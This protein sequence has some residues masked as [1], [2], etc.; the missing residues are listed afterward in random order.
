MHSRSRRLF[1]A[2]AALLLSAA[3]SAD[4]L[5]MLVQRSPL[6]GA[7]YHRLAEAWP[8]M[9]E[10]DALA[11]EREPDNRHDKRAIRVLWRGI[12][13]GYLP[14]AANFD[15][16]GEMDAGRRLSARVGHMQADP[17]P[18]KRLRIDVWADLHPPGER[19]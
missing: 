14:R 10:G 5:R 18:W 19:R 9:R 13:I 11:L 8:R 3:A 4:G 12:M 6:A 2:T 16:A 17:D 7:Q 1:C 15:A